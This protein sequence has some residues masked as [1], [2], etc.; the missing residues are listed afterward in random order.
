[1]KLNSK[2]H[3]FSDWFPILKKLLF[4]PREYFSSLYSL[5]NFLLVLSN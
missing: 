2:H 1:M 4:S 5:C 3:D